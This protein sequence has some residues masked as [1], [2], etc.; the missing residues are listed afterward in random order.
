MAVDATLS[1][2]RVIHRRTT[3]KAGGVG[4]A[5]FT[6]RRGGNMRAWFTLGCGAVMAASATFGYARV[7][8]RCRLEGSSGMTSL[9]SR[10]SGNVCGRF[11]F[12]RFTVMAACTASG[13]T[14]VVKFC[15]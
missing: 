13:D 2:A 15:A 10:C 11:A 4:V 6:S 5:S 8:H 1:N 9:T 7:V 3:F 12:G 14:S